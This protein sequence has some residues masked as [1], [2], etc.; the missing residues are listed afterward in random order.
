VRLEECS[1]LRWRPRLRFDLITCV[2]GL[3]YVGDKL[4]ALERAVAW[5]A[6]AGRLLANFDVASVKV[7]GVEKVGVT[8]ELRRAGLSYDPR[9]RIVSC[10]GPR[11]VRLPFVYEGANDAAGPNYTGQPA[12]DSHYALCRK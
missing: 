12:V 10:Q 3:H 8:R 9:R 4:A 2:H 1:I 11:A 7:T 5:L 6:P